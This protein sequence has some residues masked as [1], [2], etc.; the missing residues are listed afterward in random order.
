MVA[1]LLIPTVALAAVIATL[2]VRGRRDGADRRF[3]VRLRRELAER[4]PAVGWIGFVPG[5]FAAV[6]NLDG[7]ETHVPLRRLQ[8]RTLVFP[9]AFDRLVEQLLEEVR[10]R[11]LERAAG[12]PFAAVAA[13]LV[14]QVRSLGWLLAGR[15][16]FGDGALVARPLGSDL[17]LCVAIDRGGCLTF[18]SRELARTWGRD[19]DALLTLAVANLR[20]RDGRASLGSIDREGVVF[21]RGDGFDAARICLLDPEQAEGLCIAVPDR[22]L[23]WIGGVDDA[24]FAELEHRVAS[25]HARGSHPISPRVYRL[26]GGALAVVGGL[27]AEDPGQR[28]MPRN[29][30]SVVDGTS[31]STAASPSTSNPRIR[32]R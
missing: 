30:R 3:A 18:V 1:L 19:A 17:V 15:G 13:D 10:S 20:R 23:G 9:D 22:D 7:Q 21:D 24:D 31:N 25:L 5:E 12:L 29:S 6:L 32:T 27:A 26:I 16:R 8:Q 4:E 11:G 28:G 14:P 2:A